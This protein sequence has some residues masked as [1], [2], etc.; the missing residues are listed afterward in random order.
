MVKVSAPGLA[1]AGRGRTHGV[2]LRQQFCRELFFDKRHGPKERPV[3][4]GEPQEC[5]D[6]AILVGLEGCIDMAAIEHRT[7]VHVV[8]QRGGTAADRLDRTD[9]RSDI[10]L[11]GR[12]RHRFQRSDEVHD[13]FQGLPLEPS[14]QIILVGMMMSVDEPRSDQEPACIDDSSLGRPGTGGLKVRDPVGLNEDI[15]RTAA[16]VAGERRGGQ[17]DRVH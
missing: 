15:R 7:D 4:Q 5:A 6:A 14:L 2:E 1:F 8:Y 9:K 13:K 3:K 10:N 11:P 12:Q 16:L 17:C